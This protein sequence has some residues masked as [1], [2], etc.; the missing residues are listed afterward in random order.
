VRGQ[1]IYG[2][3]QRR[4]FV[5]HGVFLLGNELMKGGIDERR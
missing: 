2:V 5:F 1:R 4:E 3:R